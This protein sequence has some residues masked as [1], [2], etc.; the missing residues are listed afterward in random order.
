[1]KGEADWTCPSEWNWTGFGKCP[2]WTSSKCRGYHLQQILESDV[3]Q[4]PKMG[5]LPTPVELLSS[6]MFWQLE[7]LAITGGLRLSESQFMGLS[8]A[9]SRPWRH[10]GLEDGGSK[11]QWTNGCHMEAG[12]IRKSLV[13]TQFKTVLRQTLRGR[14]GRLR[15]CLVKDL[16]VKVRVLYTPTDYYTKC[17]S[18]WNVR[19]Q[20]V[21]MFEHGLFNLTKSSNALCLRTGDAFASPQ[22]VCTWLLDAISWFQHSSNSLQV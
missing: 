12:I 11:M 4:I 17:P 21:C 22:G 10:G 6:L 5:H 20:W 7:A 9:A 1:M 19:S 18:H 3:K 14:N 8:G 13:T 16:P 15:A 2:N